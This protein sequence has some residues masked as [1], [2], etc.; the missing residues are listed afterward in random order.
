VR[1]DE[2]PFIWAA[3]I[4]NTAIAHPDPRTGRILDEFDLT[5]HYD[6]WEEDM[7]LMADL[8]VSHARY[9]IPW[10][11]VNPRPGV[12]NW[13]WADR[14]LERLMAVH[15]IEPIVDLVH[16]G[17][18]VW[19]KRSFLDPDYPQR[20]AEYAA[21]FAGR[22]RG[23]CSWYTPYN[24][25]RIG[26]WWAGKL[27]RW[28]PYL[29]GNR[30]FIRVITQICRGICLTQRAVT[31]IQPDARFVHVD[32]TDLYRADDPQNPT[33]SAAANHKQDIGF[34]ALDLVMGRVDSDHPL[35]EWISPHGLTDSD[36]AWFSQYR[37]QPDIIGLNMYPMCS[38]KLVR[39]RKG[40]VETI[41]RKCW[42]ETL[43]ALVRLY[44]ERFAPIPI[45]VTETASLPRS[46][47][48]WI[49]DSTTAVLEL[50]EE[51]IPIIGYTYWP[52]FTMVAWPYQS[53][54][55]RMEDCMYRIGLWDLVKTERG[56]DRIRT[57][58]AAAYESVIRSSRAPH[59]P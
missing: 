48:R 37:V 25:P 28:P 12:F 2:T 1:L 39:L 27:G 31:E 43:E 7:A 15:R 49:K 42:T 40:R 3:G 24:E 59:S 11:L 54:I 18:P 26:A 52:L 35:R 21:A 32:A 45:M 57:P 29:R 55:R 34:L 22:Y 30:G 41:T 13:R 10:H 51:G 58:A 23:L 46:K 19:I 5:E 17:T 53:G 14:V 6:R 9:G 4:E 16:Y 33:L 20:I 50:R 38:G 47:T 44:A 8:G 56:F 36:S